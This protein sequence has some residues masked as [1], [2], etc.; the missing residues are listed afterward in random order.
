MFN[1]FCFDA[2][3]DLVYRCFFSRIGDFL[4]RKEHKNKKTLSQN[5]L[6]VF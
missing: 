4:F 3:L 6:S 2:T 1:L 5:R